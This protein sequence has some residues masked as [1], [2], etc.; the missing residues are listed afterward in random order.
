MEQIQT[1]LSR[2][3][4]APIDCSRLIP[5]THLQYRAQEL[6]SCSLSE[7]T[8]KL[9][10]TAVHQFNLFCHAYERNQTWPPN[11]N[12]LFHF[13]A[14]LSFKQFSSSTVKAYIA[15]ISYFCRIRGF[16]DTTKSFILQKVLVGFS[17]MNT[18]VDNRKPITISILQGLISILPQVCLSNYE[19][20]L[21]SALFCTAFFGYFRIGE[22][23]QDS[24]VKPGHAI[25]VG[26][27]RLSTS[28][29]VII[30]LRHSKTDQ[31]GKGATISLVPARPICPI[32]HLNKY[33]TL[34][35]NSPGAFFIHLSGYPVTRYQAE[36]VFNKAIRMLGLDTKMY[37]THS[38]RIGAASNA[39]ASGMSQMDIAGNW[40][41]EISLHV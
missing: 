25:Q 1:C 8:K 33:A 5:Q 38:F 35:P 2:S 14:Y 13:V 30:T 11:P 34:R 15:G 19:S 6:L 4:P 32:Q 7:N 28:N 27:V 23:V 37:K 21:F 10:M 9:Y 3:R 17:R 12:D 20:I 41:L 36:S 24:K 39:W 18:R 40:A 29:S 16:L 26:D 31:E 22:L